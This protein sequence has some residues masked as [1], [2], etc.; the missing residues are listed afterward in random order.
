MMFPDLSNP[1]VVVSGAALFLLT[2]AAWPNFTFRT[3]KLACNGFVVID[4]GFT[5]SGQR[6]RKK[7]ADLNQTPDV[8][9]SFYFT[10]KRRL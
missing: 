8:E 4:I 3:K 9:I 7:T 2:F 5:F 10:L 1:M 6:W